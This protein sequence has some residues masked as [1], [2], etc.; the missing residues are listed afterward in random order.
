MNKFLKVVGGC[1]GEIES[2]EFVIGS[3]E[4]VIGK[5]SKYIE[6]VGED[7]FVELLEGENFI[8]FSLDEEGSEVYFEYE[9][10]KKECDE[11]LRIYNEF[12]E[13]ELDWYDV[14]GK[15]DVIYGEMFK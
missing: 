7:E 12:E 9:K 4:G 8:G 11:Y 3:R 1:R 13:K 5:F 2:V 15:L 10:V 6:E 14:V